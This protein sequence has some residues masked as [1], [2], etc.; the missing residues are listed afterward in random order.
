MLREVGIVCLGR[1]AV[2]VGES[3][4]LC[5]FVIFEGAE[6]AEIVE[7]FV[8]NEPLSLICTSWL[9]ADLLG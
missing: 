9:R 3:E 5:I 4:L 7:I 8:R 1:T 2:E 6:E